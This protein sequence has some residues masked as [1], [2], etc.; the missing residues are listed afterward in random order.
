M[1]TLTN[2]VYCA[3][4][5]SAA[6]L[7]IKCFVAELPLW[8]ARDRNGCRWSARSATQS[9]VLR[10][11]P[12]VVISAVSDKRTGNHW[13]PLVCGAAEDVELSPQQGRRRRDN[14]LATGAVDDVTTT[15]AERPRHSSACDGQWWW[16]RRF[17]SS[18]EDDVGRY[19]RAARLCADMPQRRHANTWHDLPLSEVVRG[20][21]V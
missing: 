18:S 6:D 10:G 9:P 20:C 8:S 21:F 13:E 11:P 2:E 12:R 5:L 7:L 17:G 1:L 16:S 14:R 3:I 4:A 19:Q 15:A